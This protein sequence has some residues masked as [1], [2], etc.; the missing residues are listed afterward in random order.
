MKKICLL[1][2]SLSCTYFAH[3]QTSAV[4]IL[5][6]TVDKAHSLKSLSYDLNFTQNNPFSSGDTSS[7]KTQSTLIFDANGLIMAKIANTVLNNGQVSYTEICRND[8]LYTIDLRD[9]VYSF[10]KITD[11]SKI[12]EDLYNFI[13]ALTDNIKSPSKIFQK[14]D[15][16]FNHTPCYSFFI[17]SFDTVANGKHNYTY[18]YI[19]ISKATF[20]PAYTKQIAE[21]PAEK[22]GYDL[23]RLT[24]FSE[25]Y[26]S[27]F[28]F[29]KKTDPAVFNFNQSAFAIKNDKMLAAGETPPDLKLKDLSNREVAP[30]TFKN[31]LLLVEFGATDCSANPLAN[32]MLN[33]LKQKYS[34]ADVSIVSIYSGES[35]EKVK[36]Y[37]VSNHL[38]F[39][40]YLGSRKLTKA[41]KTVGTPNFYLI[42]KNGTILQS[43]EGFSDELEKNITGEIEKNIAR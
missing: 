41:F 1:L 26:F 37:I 22:G 7:G 28:R 16:T 29:N 38:E 25:M 17:K 34:P 24:S 33:R 20:M 6:K 3:A 5:Q 9:S 40:V 31:K 36:K 23:G 11:R 30:D 43:Y 2:L 39:P 19:L 18:N 14:R 10:D 42:S 8:T 4:T 35:V 27:N 21:F 15:T 12:Y 13:N 32:P